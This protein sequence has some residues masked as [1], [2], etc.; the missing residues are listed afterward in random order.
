MNTFKNRQN[1]SP[2]AS[3][4]DPKAMPQ[5]QL[6]LAWFGSIFSNPLRCSEFGVCG[7]DRSMFREPEIF[8]VGLMV[9]R[10]PNLQPYEVNDDILKIISSMHLPSTVLKMENEL[11]FLPAHYQN[12]C[13]EIE[14]RAEDVSAPW[15]R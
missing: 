5:Q 13:A 9:L 2:A 4:D 8:D 10:Q 1:Q 15:N 6:E 7:L 3:F 11:Q 12:Y 14:S